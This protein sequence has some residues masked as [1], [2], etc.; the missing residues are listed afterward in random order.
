MQNLVDAIRV[1]SLEMQTEKDPHRKQEL[2]KQLQ[3]LNLRKE[4]ENIQKRIKQLS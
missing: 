3:V 1:K 2:S 4:I